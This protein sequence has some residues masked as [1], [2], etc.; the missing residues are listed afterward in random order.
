[1]NLNKM[2]FLIVRLS[3]IGDVMHATA[4]AHT[5][6][7]HAPHCH[8][9]WLASPPASELLRYDPDIDKLIIWDRN[10]FER[11]AA[12]FSLHDLKSSL[13]KLHKLFAPYQFD[14]VL[15]IHGLFLTGCISFL[16][17]AK[18]RIGIRG[19]HEFNSLFMTELAPMIESPH[20]IQ[21]YA[22]VLQPLGVRAP[23]PHLILKLPHTLHEF[24]I[25][26]LQKRGIDL[27]LPILMVSPCTTWDSKNWP[28][29]N[30]IQALDPLPGNVQ[31]IF[32]GTKNDVK[33][34]T[35]IRT[36]M[37]H[38]SFSIAGETTL[39]ELAALFYFSSLL[40]TGDTGPLHIATAVGLATLSLWGPT[41]PEIYGPLIPGHVS[42]VSSYKCTACL[43]SHCHHGSNACMRS[44]DASVVESKIRKLLRSKQCQKQNALK[45]D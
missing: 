9:T 33:N 2:H 36:K 37:T 3:S 5:L 25:H 18:R 31:I 17:K 12:N 4:V 7:L 39:P 32:C 45:F 26:F 15:D 10:A 1:M 29:A 35:N 41:L 38:S 43:K 40:L 14:I 27:T 22:A 21:Q 24:A 8:I 11:A 44:I 23:D 19:M 16:A 30:F 34:I 20:K 13:V 42:I 28:A 6:R